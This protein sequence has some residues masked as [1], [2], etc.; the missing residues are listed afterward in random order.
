MNTLTTF[1]MTQWMIAQQHIAAR[2][3]RTS[4]EGSQ[5]T[6]NLLWII[7]VIAV[8]GLATIALTTY[9]N[10]LIGKVA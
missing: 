2:S 1:L 4:E 3:N 6:D 8:A 9:V 7:A 5:T 10:G